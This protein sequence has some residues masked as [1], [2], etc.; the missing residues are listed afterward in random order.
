MRRVKESL[1]AGVRPG[2]VV[3]LSMASHDY[4][5]PEGEEGARQ[6]FAELFDQPADTHRVIKGFHFISVTTTEG[7]KFRQPQLDF[8]ARELAIARD[9]APRKPIF[10]F[11]HPHLSDTVYGSIGWGQGAL[12]PVLVNYPQIIDFSGHSHAPINDPRNVH[13]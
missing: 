1:D 11:Q 13:Q 3:N 2:T 8:A 7:C 12:M 4:K 6:R 9:D 5:G 10:F